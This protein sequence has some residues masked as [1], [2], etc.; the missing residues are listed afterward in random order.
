MMRSGLT[1]VSCT[2]DTSLKLFIKDRHHTHKQ[3][4][5]GIA[6]EESS[7]MLHR[8]ATRTCFCGSARDRATATVNIACFSAATSVYQHQRKT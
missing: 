8:L 7:A 5:R 1:G 2:D 6:L 3:S 4:W